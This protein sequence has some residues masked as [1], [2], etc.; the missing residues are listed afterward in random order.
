MVIC[1]E[2]PYYPT[3]EEKRFPNGWWLGLFVLLIIFTAFGTGYL[4]LRPLFQNNSR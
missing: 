1:L 4:I 2:V 3:S